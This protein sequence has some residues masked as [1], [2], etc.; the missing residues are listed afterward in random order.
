MVT[1]SSP[2][3]LTLPRKG[4]GNRVLDRASR[5]LLSAGIVAATVFGLVS[6][7]PEVREQ[8]REAAA[9][10]AE[11]AEPDA[12][13]F[14]VIFA[15]QLPFDRYFNG[16]QP[17]IGV[18]GGFSWQD[19]VWAPYVVAGHGISERVMPALDGKKQAWVVLSTMA[20]GEASWSYARWPSGAG[21]R[22][23][24]AWPA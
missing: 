17:R 23:I 24:S 22:S 5:V 13:L 20:G 18:P 21:R 19:G 15:T 3:I 10:V 9:L 11:R 1:C 6:H 7:G 8:W 12:P 14:F 16:P 4:G 2:P